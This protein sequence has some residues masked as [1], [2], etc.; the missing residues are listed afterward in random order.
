MW[1]ENELVQTKKDPVWCLDEVDKTGCPL[2]DLCDL[3][4][5]RWWDV[6][7]WIRVRVVLGG[8]TG[9]GCRV[10]HSVLFW[11]VLLTVFVLFLI[12]V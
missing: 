3:L 8:N 10:R 2:L 5:G 6:H 1:L 11:Y 12:G 9:L 4:L 7:R